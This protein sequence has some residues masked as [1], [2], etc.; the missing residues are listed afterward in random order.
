MLDF[1]TRIIGAR[2]GTTFSGML[3]GTRGAGAGLIEAEAG[4]KYLRKL[5]QELPALQEY[6][7]LERILLDPELLAM[8]LRKPRSA[9]EKTS[10]VNNILSG[11]KTVGIGMTIPAGSRAI[12]LGAQEFAEP[13]QEPIIPPEEPD[14][15]PVSSVAPTA[16]PAPQPVPA[17]PVAPPP[18]TTLASAAP[19]P[20]PPAASGPV[21]RRRFAAMF[22]EDRSLIE[23]IGSLMG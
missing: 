5:T 3:P 6:D 11:L 19:P 4:S 7:A 16:M 2:A 23:G 10:I 8:A 13:E 15:G 22:P 17:Q 9:S 21:D 14:V 20:P 12:P 1:Y 18:T